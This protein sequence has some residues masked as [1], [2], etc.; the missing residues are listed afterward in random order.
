MSNKLENPIK[1]FIVFGGY[2]RVY[3]SNSIV[4]PIPN[5]EIIVPKNTSHYGKIE[6]NFSK[7]NEDK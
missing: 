5:L 2:A 3:S 1:D 4:N 6:F 7:E